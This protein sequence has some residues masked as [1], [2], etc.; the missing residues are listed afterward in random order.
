MRY[1]KNVFYR[2]RQ[3]MSIQ[4][5][6][7]AIPEVLKTRLWTAASM[8]ACVMAAGIFMEYQLGDGFLK[9]SCLCSI[10]LGIRFF[11]L[12]L[13]IYDR[14]YEVVEGEVV[15]IRVCGIQKKNWEITVRNQQG[16]EKTVF[17]SEQSNIRKGRHYRIYFKKEA[18]L[19]IEMQGI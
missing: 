19:G 4:N 3:Y 15:R 1:L 6:Q 12:L 8:I 18:I 16:E 17:I 14:K 5:N 13:I 10:C 2:L 9:L 7:P 11:D